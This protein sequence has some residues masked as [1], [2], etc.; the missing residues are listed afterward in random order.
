VHP[1]LVGHLAVSIALGAVGGAVAGVF[2]RLEGAAWGAAIMTGG[3]L[4]S[5]AISALGR[6]YDAPAGK[7]WLAATLGNPVLLLSFLLMFTGVGWSCHANIYEC[8]GPVLAGVLAALCCVP[9]GVGLLL[10]RRRPGI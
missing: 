10:R 8:G 2:G 7:L 6:G 5:A 9:P 4:V 1:F 3:A